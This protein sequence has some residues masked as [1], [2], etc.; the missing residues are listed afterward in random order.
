MAKAQSLEAKLARLREL[1]GQPHSPQL[2]EE[3]AAALRDSSNF[4]VADAAE[5]IGKDHFSE[6]A[7]NLVEA[8]TRFLDKPLKKDKQCRAKIAVVEALNQLEFT[9]ENF[10][11]RGVH[12]VQAE[13]V[14]EG[15]RDTAV[16]IRVACASSLVRLRH[17]D[18]M[19]L[20]VDMLATPYSQEAGKAVRAGAAQI[21]TYAATEAAALLLRLKVRLGD[22]EEEVISECFTGILEITKEAGVPFVAESLASGSQAIQEAALLALG[23]SRQAAAFGILKS[24]AE[25]CIGEI[26]ETAHVALALL[27]LPAATDLLLSLVA[28]RS[29]T[30][31]ENAL[32]ALAVHRYDP[33]V[34]ERTAA[35]VAQNGTAALR[36]LFAKRFG[37]KE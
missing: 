32:K 10:Y 4:V 27:R 26:Q 13:P 33:R 3:L 22:P 1:S 16:P 12:Y 5:L 25:K 20:L 7:P 21:L 19:P 14:W 30:V 18:A 11:L 28:D 24:F 36:E 17:P 34:R 31:A 8:F 23:S 35:A 15:T 9:N 6:L 2:I 37:A 29:P